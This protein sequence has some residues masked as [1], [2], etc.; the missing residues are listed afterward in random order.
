MVQG[1]VEEVNGIR[2]VVAQWS[3]NVELELPQ[4]DSLSINPLSNEH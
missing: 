4:E 2:L 3:N 1:G